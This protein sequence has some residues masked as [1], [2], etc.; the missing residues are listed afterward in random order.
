MNNVKKIA[1]IALLFIIVGGIGSVV[2]FNDSQATSIAQAKEVDNTNITEVDIR[3]HN[4]EVE[5]M[6]TKDSKITIELTGKTKDKNK[7]SVKENENTLSIQSDSQN[8]KLFSF[9]FFVESLTLTVYLPEKVYDTLQI[10]SDNGKIELEQLD[11]KDVNVTT[12]NGRIAMETIGAEKVQV[13]TINGK[14]ALNK[15]EGSITGKIN[16]GSILLN[17]KDLDRSIDFETNNGSITVKTEKKPTNAVFDVKVGNG[18]INIFGDSNWDTV[19]G[20][21]DNLIKLNTNNGSIT[22]E[23]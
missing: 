16:N 2:T 15:V 10:D 8:K 22:V 4:E 13:G 7:L 23:K 12:K 21:G 11:I 19:V 18:K 9:D 20:N 5:I 6:S 14:I 1:L 17:T 3:T